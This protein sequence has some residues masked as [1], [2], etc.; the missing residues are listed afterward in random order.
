MVH[1]LDTH[2]D[3]KIHTSRDT[4]AVLGWKRAYKHKI[5]IGLPTYPSIRRKKVSVYIYIYILNLVSFF[6][7][8]FHH[9]FDCMQLDRSFVS[10]W[11]RPFWISPADASGKQQVERE[12]DPRCS[13]LGGCGQRHQASAR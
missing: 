10:L 6:I 7:Q 3:V 8:L 13:A 11:H 12:E 4:N 2:V 9:E 1:T 5:Y